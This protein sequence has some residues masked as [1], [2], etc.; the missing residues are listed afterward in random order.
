M[1]QNTSRFKKIYAPI[2]AILDPSATLMTYQKEI[3]IIVI[4]MHV[5]NLDRPDLMTFQQDIW[6]Q[7]TW[8]V[9]NMF[10]NELL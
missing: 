6:L 7:K 4:P 5:M 10:L 9:E 8:W 3:S 1:L 2:R